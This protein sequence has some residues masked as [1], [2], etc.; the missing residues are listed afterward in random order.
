MFRVSGY[1]CVNNDPPGSA[2]LLIIQY[3]PKYG[4]MKKKSTFLKTL[5]ANTS[6]LILILLASCNTCEST[7][8]YHAPANLGEGLSIGTLEEVGVDTAQISEAVRQI[9]CGSFKE[10]HSM[11]IY[12]DGMLVLEEYFPGHKYQWDAPDYFGEYVQWNEGMLHPVMSCSKSFTSACI[13]IAIDKGYIRDVHEKIFDFLPDH[14]EF[15]NGGKENITIEH[16]LT[17]TSGLAWDEW[18]AMHGTSA[19]D[20]DRLYFDCS[21]DPIRCVLERE[22]E[23]R[24]GEVFNYNG[25]GIV[26]LGEIIKNASGMDMGEFSELYLFDPLGIDSTSWF[27]YNNGVYATDGSLYLRP[28]DMMKFGVMYLNKGYWNGERILPEYWITRSS[29]AYRNN[30]KIKVP[31]EDSGRNDYGYTWWITRHDHK[32]KTIKMF[33]ANGWGGQTIMVFPEI[34]MVVVFTCGNYAFNSKLFRLIDRYILPAI[35]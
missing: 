32:G 28:R 4:P 6:F 35:K 3:K 10:V 11:L 15:R 26:M 14:Q 12:K 2:S 31:I 20:I 17:M 23:H 24:P 9:K 13:G 22:L 16:L 5:L 7:Y 27:Q 1:D 30:K 19:N 8:D 33:R 29:E 25:G 18:G 21:D 34:D